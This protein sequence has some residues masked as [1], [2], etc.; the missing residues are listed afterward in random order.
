MQ[1][2]KK[3]GSGTLANEQHFANCTS[4]PKNEKLLRCKSKSVSVS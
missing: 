2:K 3:D 1:Q 4:T